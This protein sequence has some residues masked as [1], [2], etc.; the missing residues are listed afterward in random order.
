M[1]SLCLC[2]GIRKRITP[3]VDSHI[4]TKSVWERS[5]HREGG[6]IKTHMGKSLVWGTAFPYYQE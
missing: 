5:Q 4:A 3:D 1:P 6:N 2:I